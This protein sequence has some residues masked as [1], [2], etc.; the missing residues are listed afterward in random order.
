MTARAAPTRI[1]SIFNKYIERGGEEVAVEEICAALARHP[2]E[3]EPR[4]L[5]FHSADWRR[6]PVP[7]VWKK[8]RW[9][10]RNPTSI[11]R[12]RESQSALRAD[13]WLAHNLFPVGSA[14]IYREA[15][16]LGVPMIQYLHNYRP[17]SVSGYLWDGEKLAPGG[18]RGSF[19]QEIR[20]GAWQDSQLKTAGYAVVLKAMHALGW[21]EAVKSWVAISEFMRQRF[22]EAG[23][24]AERIFTAP[25]F[26][27]AMESPPAPRDD[28]YFLFL[29]RLITAKGVRVLFE[30]WALVEEALGSRAPRLVI[31]GAGPLEGSV[32]ECCGRRE[33]VE[34]A[35]HVSG[36][37]KAELIAGCSAMVAPS[38]WWEPLGLV[39]YEAYDFQKPMLAAASG[40]LTETVVDGETGLLHEPGNARQLAEQVLALHSDP[41]RR[42]AMGANGRAWLVG[43]TNEALWLQRFDR[44]VE[45]AL[46][47]R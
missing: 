27:R 1:L 19:W 43:N 5:L 47:G 9:F 21:F 25:H 12:L 7:S 24:P 46:A 16:R 13:C 38:I 22:I 40:G 14:A 32:R 15:L 2:A 4:E 37:K 29:G 34:F 17:F 45:Y 26:W 20:A 35:G 39:T 42:A 41:G 30:A 3:F 36:E 10:V 23:V 31:A 18:L 6:E 11:A 28:G 33:R 8:A 44:A